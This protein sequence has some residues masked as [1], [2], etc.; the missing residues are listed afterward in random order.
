MD[1]EP[2]VIQ[3]P[4]PEHEIVLE[5]ETTPD[6]PV[7]QSPSISIASLSDFTIG[8]ASD[9]ESPVDPTTIIPHDTFYLEDG[10]VEVLCGKTLF[11][12]HPTILSFHSA[13]LR[14]MFAQAN[15]ATAESPNDCP[16]ILSSDKAPDFATLLKMI[17][18]PEYGALYLHR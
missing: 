12:V 6:P 15:L 11:R 18:L 14:Q 16:R 4:S 1:S 13:A 10:N 2:Q 5:T 7:I 8:D 3:P 9:D 17:Y